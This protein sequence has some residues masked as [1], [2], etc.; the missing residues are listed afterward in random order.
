MV[1]DVFNK[2]DGMSNAEIYMHYYPKV[3]DITVAAVCISKVLKR[4]NVQ[5]LLNKL[6]E[7]AEQRAIEASVM[8]TLEKEQIL[9]EIAR[10]KPGDFI[11]TEG[12]V[13]LTESN[14]NK[15]GISK[16]KVTTGPEDEDGIPAWKSVT[17]D[18]R[19]QIAAIREHNDMLGIGKVSRLELTGA[20]GG[21]IEVDHRQLLIGRITSIIER[22]REG[23]LPE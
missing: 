3:K 16:I 18:F 10:A 22:N 13:K 7:E 2:P 6:K 9:T 14:L 12:K 4:A 15:A 5:A 19:D 17:L 11:D 8:S 20:N 23:E 21:P 1:L